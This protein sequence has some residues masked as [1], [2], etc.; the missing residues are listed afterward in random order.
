MPYWSLYLSFEIPLHLVWGTEKFLYYC[1]L[2]YYIYCKAIN[3]Q[4]FQRAE[5]ACHSELRVNRK[6]IEIL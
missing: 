2:L 3:V 6:V 4:A 1:T 5:G